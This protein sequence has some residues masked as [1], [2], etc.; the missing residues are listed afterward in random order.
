MFVTRIY[1]YIYRAIKMAAL[2]GY[3]FRTLKI[4]F[5]AISPSFVRTKFDYKHVL[6]E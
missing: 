3:C 6:I 1:I 2:E 4:I 5:V